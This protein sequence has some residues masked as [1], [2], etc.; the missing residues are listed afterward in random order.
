MNDNLKN[1]GWNQM[2][3][4]L[5]SEMP[6]KKAW[7]MFPF[8]KAAAVIVPLLLASTVIYYQVADQVFSIGST[9]P[10]SELKA[11][12]SSEFISTEK[13]TKVNDLED[14]NKYQDF[15]IADI[16]NELDS[17]KK[18]GSPHFEGEIAATTIESSFELTSEKEKSESEPIGM[19]EEILPIESGIMDIAPSEKEIS[20][21]S[22]FPEG[23]EQVA[24]HE[25]G[26][27]EFTLLNQL[28]GLPLSLFKSSVDSLEYASH[29]SKPFE[30]DKKATHDRRYRGMA[31]NA[32]WEFP[33]QQKIH[34][35]GIATGPVFDMGQFR[36]N[37]L[38]GIHHYG[39]FNQSGSFA[40][41][42]SRSSDYQLA[43]DQ[44]ESFMQRFSQPQSHALYSYTEIS[45]E[46]GAHYKIHSRWQ[47][48][49]GIT[50]HR[51]FNIRYDANAIFNSNLGLSPI[52]E[53]D[54]EQA[55]VLE[56]I[57]NESVDWINP[58]R[59]TAGLGLQFN[60]SSNYAI[61][62]GY[63]QALSPF[64]T[65]ENEGAGSSIHA[66]LVIHAF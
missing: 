60:M 23:K 15:G 35:V 63:R 52:F 14:L 65:S 34:G 7:W 44:S 11:K 30:T 46:L 31:I 21:V 26:K 22:E 6:V 59:L 5:D 32:G 2:R 58:Y 28:L 66:A 64:W 27:G 12:S 48:T 29:F 17:E 43:A 18:I 16:A 56:Y 10:D 45:L 47:I 42:Q 57:G 37:P 51:V 55:E 40:L 62:M 20:E 39:F 50:A 38:L 19:G 49:G 8:W 4:L 25:K 1:R 13:A 9:A 41:F 3:E 36:I 54:V 24:S 53:E 33:L 61:R